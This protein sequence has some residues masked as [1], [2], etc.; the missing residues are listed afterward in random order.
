[1]PRELHVGTFF[2]FGALALFVIVSVSAPTWS[3]L[4]FLKVNYN[5]NGSNIQLVFG[6]LGYCVRE[7]TITH[8]SNSHVGYDIAQLIASA[9]GQPFSSS[10][11]STLNNLSKALVLHPIAAGI[12]GLALLVALGAHRIGFIFASLIA[13]VGWIVAV[14]ALILDFVAFTIARRHINNTNIAGTNAEYSIAIWLTLA[15]YIMLFLGSITVWF[16]CFRERRM[17]SRYGY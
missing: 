4:G 1:M 11:A 10:T 7:P 15:G 3:T 2:L 16:G 12:T 6:T 17:K 5:A 14:L 8:C 13:T 9:G